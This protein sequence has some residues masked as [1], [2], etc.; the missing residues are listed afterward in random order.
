VE[1][2][3]HKNKRGLFRKALKVGKIKDTFM[4]CKNCGNEINPG[5]LACLGCG[6]DPKKGKNNCSNCGVIINPEQIICIKCGCSTN[7]L[8]TQNENG[9]IVAIISYITIVGYIIALFENRKNRTVLGTY[10]LLQVTGFMVT[11][12]ILGVVMFILYLP[13]FGM[14]SRALADYLL[15]ISIISFPVFISLV[16]SSIIS[17]IN[18]INEKIKPAPIYGKLFDRWFGIN[19]YDETMF[20]EEKI[21]KKPQKKKS[22]FLDFII[23]VCFIFACIKILLSIIEYLY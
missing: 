15:I 9:K 7:N 2:S 13:A 4:Y 8:P 23:N 10:H 16:I 11:G 12:I 5:A 14:R 18:A 17:F 19:S 20:A 1:T 3:N 6:C 21:I 22:S